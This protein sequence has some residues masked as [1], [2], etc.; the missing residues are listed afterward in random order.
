MT[1][2]RPLIIDAYSHIVPQEYM[3]TLSKIAPDDYA[4]KIKPYPALYDLDF[5][6]GILDH[7]GG[8]VQV[9][10]PAWPPVENVADHKESPELAR[11][12]N[13]GI[14]ELVSKYPQRFI[15][16]IA[17]LPMNNMEAALK[18]ID[19][20]VNDLKFR[21]VLVHTPVN[22]KP[23]DLPEFMPLYEKMQAYNLPIFIHPMR[24]FSYPDYKT[25]DASKYGIASLFGWPYETTTAMTRLVLSGVLE[26]YP[27]LKIVTH[28][29]GAMVPYFAQRIINFQDGFEM[30]RR[31]DYFKGL[32]KTPIEYF[33][34]FYA[35]LALYGNTPAMMCAYDFFGADKL[36]FGADMPLGDN[37]NG[38]RNYRQTINAIEAMDIPEEARKLIYEDNARKLM[39]LPI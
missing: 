35:D 32:T 37:L 39:R 23:L 9:L 11:M 38:Y 6:F 13:D 29:G 22:D 28:H 33:K 12:A 16:G 24:P 34:M 25:E 20:A 27:D 19:R 17:C 15:A 21:G 31:W 8:I 18:E 5:R 2:P 26:K 36:L 3:E 30:I 14:A 4:D 10:T 1:Q 7:F